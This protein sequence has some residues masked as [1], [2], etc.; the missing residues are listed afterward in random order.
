MVFLNPECNIG[1]QPRRNSSDKLQET[2]NPT[3]DKTFN[4]VAWSEP[5]PK[6]KYEFG[7]LTEIMILINV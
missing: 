5:L 2:D 4:I 7:L 1:I 6:K 3:H